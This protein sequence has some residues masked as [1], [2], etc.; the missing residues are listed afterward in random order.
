MSELSVGAMSS[1]R[2]G[3]GSSR[4]RSAPDLLETAANLL[5]QATAGEE[6][7][8]YVSRSRE[9]SVRAFRGEVESLS[10][11]ESTGAGIRVVSDGRQG[12]AY[13]ASL[14]DE[15]LACALAD[16]R[17]NARFATRDD[18]CGLAVPD[19]APVVAVDAWSSE[20]ESFPLDGKVT[21]A[22]ELED[23]VRSGDPRIREVPLADYDDEI[24]EQAVVST[25]GI[26]ASTRRSWCSLS[27]QAIA[28][29]GSDSV[30]SSGFAVARNPSSLDSDTAAREALERSVRLL[31]A[32]PVRSG[33]LSVVMDARVTAA[34]LSVLAGAFSGER[35]QRGQ[36]FLAD[37]SGEQVASDA[38]SI[39][40]DP[41][42]PEALGASSYDS[43]GIACRRQVLVDSGTLSGFV[44]DTYAGRLAGL[45]SS[46][47]AVRSGFS[48]TPVAGCRAVRFQPGPE[49]MSLEEVLRVVQNGLFVQSISGV[50]SGVNTVSGDFSVGAEG[51]MI[52]DGAFA[53]PVREVTI[54]STMQ[55]MLQSVLVVGGDLQ[56][57]PGSAA[58][59][60]LA[61]GD[62]SVSG[63]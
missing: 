52:R 13:A 3:S 62:L 16:A 25:S 4:G 2:G 36:S 18:C 38:V 9:T 29:D 26:Q 39:I 11:A 63:R 6:I 8:V 53:E 60:P 37:R 61:V 14:D 58:G 30:T 51:L 45:P 54:A 49:E 34:F 40:E 15:L 20:L 43:E 17:D 59:Q 21:M 12:F 5:A 10:S 32:R 42:D 44:Y 31:G 28:A 7:E 1:L 50:H 46:G 19:G 24:I 22:L 27:V 23:R 57:L 35:V 47:S 56:W 48:G 33:R 41:T 55:R